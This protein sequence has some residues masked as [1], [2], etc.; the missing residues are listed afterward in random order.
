MNRAETQHWMAE[1]PR[2]A[3]ALQGRDVVVISHQRWDSHFTPVH[4]TT[5][6]LAQRNRVLLMEPPDSA[7]GLLHHRGA[8]VA[9]MRTFNRLERFGSSLGLYHVPPLFMPFQPY[10][11]LILRSIEATYLWMVRDGI[12]KMGLR[13]PIFWAFQFNISRV[14]DALSPP[15][16][17][18][19][20]VEEAAGFAKRERV[21]K[22]IQEMDAKLCR[23]ADV[24]FVPNEQMCEARRSIARGIHIVP[25]PVDFEHYNRAMDPALPVPDDLR[26]IAPPIIGFYGNFDACR[27]DVPLIVGLARRRPDWN[28]VLIGRLWPGFDPAPLK[29]FSNIHLLGPRALEQLPAYIK[30]FDVGLIPYALNDYTRSITPLKLM[31]YLASGKQVVTTPLPSALAH[32]D[33][34][35]IARDIDEFEAQ[36]AAALANPRDREVERLRVARENNWDAYMQRKTGVV[37]ALLD[38]PRG[39]A[40]SASPG[41]VVGAGIAGAVI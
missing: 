41:R 7:A 1:I 28:F 36:L 37:A 30:G 39:I 20:C 14:V 24:V 22:Y 13:D 17:V 40:V 25:W 8:R 5:L 19:E 38:S 11:R 23:R 26:A 21:R 33:V 3:T 18:Y 6:R 15:V 4:G 12:R 31:E 35:R 2:C 10:S 29:E 32:G 34:L 9:L 16:S 27:V